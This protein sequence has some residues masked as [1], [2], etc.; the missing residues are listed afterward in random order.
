MSSFEIPDGPANVD[1]SQSVP[2]GPAN[3][4]AIFTVNNIVDEGRNGQLS[5]KLLGQAQA[6]W[7]AVDGSETIKL[8]PADSRTVAVK[9]SVPAGAPAGSHAFKLCI[10]AVNDP[11]N[12]FVAGPATTIVVPDAP[13]A[14]KPGLPWWVWLIAGLVLLGVV[15]G[16][17]WAV[18]RKGDAP[19]SP[20]V[21]STAAPNGNAVALLAAKDQV[22]RWSAAMTDG[23]ADELVKLSTPPFL[24]EDNGTL[25]RKPEI[26]DMYEQAIAQK[27]GKSFAFTRVTP[28]LIGDLESEGFDARRLPGIAAL[29]LKETDIVALAKL[30]GQDG[31]VFY[32]RRQ[33]NAV[34]CVGF[35]EWDSSG[36]AAGASA[37]FAP[38]F[39]VVNSGGGIGGYDLRSS[40]DR[41]FAFDF[42]HSGKL[43]H[44]ALY[45]PATGT[46]W[47]LK[48]QNGNFTPVYQQ[49]D[50]G[51]GIGG[52]DLRSPADQAFAFDYD[53]SGKQDHIALFRPATGTMWILKHENGG[54]RAVYAQ[55]DPGNGIGGYDLRSPA[56]Q[57]FAFDYDHSGKQDHIVLYRPATG[58][59]WILKNVNG[60]FTPVYHE[61]DPGNGIAGYDLKSPAD[62]VFAFDFDHS[63]KAD[64]LVLYRPGTGTMWILKHS[65]NGFIPV[66]Q[67]GDPGHG[68]GGY[69]L[70]SPNDRAFAY[71]YDGSGKL[72]HLALY[73]PGTGT[74]WILRNNRGTFTPVYQQGDPGTGIGG[75]DIRSTSDLAFAF[76][77]NH[78]GRQNS[79]V[80]YRPG[81][82][83]YWIVRR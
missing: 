24:F 33:G 46:M 26:R 49:G 62:R 69:D 83:S 23:D 45:R 39:G 13:A 56:D 50:P 18:T 60:N 76:D 82:G 40:A 22:T 29:D 70:R 81:S 12:D 6:S 79:I 64:H 55:G 53:H 41:S 57:A 71:D 1:L 37:N 38:V 19:V 35:S 25:S 31:L 16:I 54:F 2:E 15:G 61:G 14:P 77:F 42:D 51:N 30:G 32:F 74:M 78:T 21:V 47:I 67:Q 7:F 10:A 8:D 43:D 59:L 17:I 66:Y 28:I 63:G 65:G 20:P 52:Y 27:D 72:D 80:L 5:I 48:N 75:F 3:G 34:D 11:D 73:R 68:I 4:V 58:T 36:V 9:V 44:L